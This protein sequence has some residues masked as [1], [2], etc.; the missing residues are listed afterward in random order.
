MKINKFLFLFFF[1]SYHWGIGQDLS[2]LEAKQPITEKD[3]PFILQQLKKSFVPEGNLQYEFSTN[4]LLRDQPNENEKVVTENDLK[5]TLEK[6]KDKPENIQLLIIAANQYGLLNHPKLSEKYYY[7]ALD[8]IAKAV[9][10]DPKNADHYQNA[11]ICY[12]GLSNYQMMILSYEKA[13]DLDSTRD[14]IARVFLPLAYLGSGFYIKVEE[15]SKQQLLKYPDDRFIHAYYILGN[16]FKLMQ[17]GFD[18]GL[19][20]KKDFFETYSIYQDVDTSLMNISLKKYPED[21]FLNRV[22][23]GIKMYELLLKLFIDIDYSNLKIELSN[24]TKKEIEELIKINTKHLKNN[25]NKNPYLEYLS[26]GLLHFCKQDYKSAINY[27]EKAINSIPVEK[28][29]KNYNTAAAYDDIIMVHFF[30]RDTLKAEKAL[31][32][33]IAARPNIYKNPADYYFKA[34]INI[35][36]ND[37]NNVDE[38]INACFAADSNFNKAKILSVVVLL[39]ENKFSQAQEILETLYTE[40][41]DDY[42]YNFCYGILMLMKN[43]TNTAK[44]FFSKALNIIPDDKDINRI[45]DKYYK[46]P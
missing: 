7:K 4:T 16:I 19:K 13:L 8:L 34:L 30:N 2:R 39:N 27:Y 21:L 10:N 41:K 32:K 45:I 37:W 33:K 26:L 24:K 44:I 9:K 43:D 42:Y 17:N 46:L 36:K 12:T 25:F 22:L 5:N 40:F 35:Y 3:F 31:D 20:P 18:Y 1:L 15:Y 28:Q 38:N 29:N 6:L 14:T 11:G 23:H